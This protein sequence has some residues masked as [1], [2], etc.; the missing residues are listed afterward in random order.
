MLVAGALSVSGT[1]RTS[2]DAERTSGIE[3]VADTAI[4]ARRVS[5]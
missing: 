4:Q 1:K 5:F 2:Q 3:G